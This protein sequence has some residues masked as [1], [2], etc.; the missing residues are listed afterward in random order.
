MKDERWER[1]VKKI[2]GAIQGIQ[3]PGIPEA[4]TKTQQGKLLDST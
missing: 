4:G 3:Y 2:T 1:K